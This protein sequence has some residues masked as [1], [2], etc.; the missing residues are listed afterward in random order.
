MARGNEDEIEVLLSDIS[1]IP[2]R[3][4]KKE[5]LETIHA[6]I[7]ETAFREN[8]PELARLPVILPKNEIYD[9]IHRATHHFIDTKEP[10]WLN[11]VYDLAESLDRKSS[12]SQILSE[13]TKNLI[14]SGVDHAD[15]DLIEAGMK[16]FHQISFRKYRSAILMDIVPLHIVWSITIRDTTLLKEALG[17]IEGIGDI[18]KRSLLQ[19]EV[20]KAIGRI[21]IAKREFNLIIDALRDAAGIKQK[22]RRTNSI[23]SIIGQVWKSPLG[24]SIS[25]IPAVLARM[26]GLEEEQISEITAALIGEKIRRA[27]DKGAV[28]S[29]LEEVLKEYPFT[30]QATITE[31]LK[32]AEHFGDPYYLES[33]LRFNTQ[34][35]PSDEVQIREIIRAGISVVERTGEAKFLLDIVPIVEEA[36]T[37]PRAYAIYLQ[38]VHTM[39]QRGAFTHAVDIYT[40]ITSFT[41]LIQT[42]T[43]FW[44]TSVMLVSAGVLRDR[45]DQIRDQVFARMDT[46]TRENLIQRSIADICKHTSLG[47]IIHHISSLVALAGMHRHRDEQ[48]LM[49]IDLLIERRFIETL[50]PSY[51]V[52]IARQISNTG[53]SG[54]A[55][56]RIV[57]NIADFG[58][59]HRNR[60]YL[61]RAVGLTCEIRGQKTRSEALCSVIDRAADLAVNQGDLT[62]L[63]RMRSWTD[64]LLEKEYGL[65]TTGNIVLGMVKYGIDK[66]A[67]HALENA[68]DIAG[69]IDDP[70]LRQQLYEQIIEGYIRVG[71]L[72]M[73]EAISA[74]NRDLLETRISV[75]RRATDILRVTVTERRYSIRIARG[76]DIITEYVHQTKNPY[77]S[78][79]LVMFVLEIKSAVE[80]DAMITRVATEFEPY[81]DDVASTDPYEMMAFLLQRLEHAKGLPE[82]MELTRSLLMRIGNLYTRFSGMCTLAEGYLRLHDTERAAEILGDVRRGT[83]DMGIPHERALILSDSAGLIARIDIDAGYESF[84]EAFTLLPEIDPEMGGIVRKHL[85]FSLVSLHALRAD[86]TNTAIAIRLI[87]AI[88]EPVDFVNSL[89]AAFGIVIQGGQTQDV[90]E[91]IYAGIDEI[92]LAYDRASM[93]LSVVPIAQKYGENGDAERL[94]REATNLTDE[95]M[96]PL[97]AAMVRKGIC[98]MYLMLSTAEHNEDYRNEGIRVIETIEEEIIRHRIFQQLGLKDEKGITDP[99]YKRLMEATQEMLAATPNHPD[100]SS[101]EYLIESLSDR[102]Q[103]AR[104]C[105]ELFLLLHEAERERAADAILLFGLDEASIIRPLS[106]RVYVLCDLALSLHEAGERKK[107]RDIIGMAVN[108]ATNIRQDDLRDEVF[109]ELDVAMRIIQEERM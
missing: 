12:Q 20:T 68:Y 9:Y 22:I 87:N 3:K 46:E 6:T 8:H 54:I 78:I 41:E 57:T 38:L 62:L 61:Q 90:M 33:A 107:S 2:R 67:P 86:E 35:S 105:F 16:T 98:Q 13:V 64:P 47:E 82:V 31:L 4:E 21:G 106:R 53:I 100:L 48:L 15:A 43:Q 25:D 71:C 63:K 28:I 93:L 80:R 103:R 59:S 51:L 104:Y 102:A 14:E 10:A 7:L 19:S 36:V 49:A 95:I 74:E 72:M 108:A 77:Y 88:E 73:R 40:R 109:N 44:D 84:E 18:S 42:G 66:K 56:S 101:I 34:L 32:A 85:V 96:I 1:Q 45:V 27:H 24:S 70:S 65:Y 5:L 58:V 97:V 26:E 91:S 69:E 89:V 60:D 52:E 55:V 75:F 83:A 30:L 29:H 92:P 50:D 79:P 11:A 76:I 94:L 23:D 99:A 37:G 17:L 81:I 39:L